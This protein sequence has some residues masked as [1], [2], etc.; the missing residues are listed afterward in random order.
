MIVD[1]HGLLLKSCDKK[2]NIMT[3]TMVTTKFFTE[4]QFSFEKGS[5]IDDSKIEFCLPFAELMHLVKGLNPNRSLIQFEYPVG[6][7]KLKVSIPQEDEGI[8][9]Q[10]L[11]LLDVYEVNHNIQHFEDQNN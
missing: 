1:K 4:N 2:G 6:D 11:I 9:I 5:A 10:T 8:L 3:K 7:N